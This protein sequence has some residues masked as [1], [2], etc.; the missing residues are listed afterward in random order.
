MSEIYPAHPIWHF[1]KLFRWVLLAHLLSR[2]IL[3]TNEK[4]FVKILAFEQ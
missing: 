3:F 1:L 2:I 4:Y